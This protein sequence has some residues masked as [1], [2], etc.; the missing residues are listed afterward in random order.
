MTA[1]N[2]VT[3]YTL[4]V[5]AFPGLIDNRLDPKKNKIFLQCCYKILHKGPMILIFLIWVY[6]KYQHFEEGIENHNSIIFLTA[7][8]RS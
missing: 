3:L 5:A 6:S 2:L 7:V 1:N 8:D 4:S